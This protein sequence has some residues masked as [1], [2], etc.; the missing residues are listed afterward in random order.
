MRLGCRC[1]G[2]VQGDTIVS[3]AG[4][5]ST[6]GMPTTGPVNFDFDYNECLEY[7]YLSV[8]LKDRNGKEIQVSDIYPLWKDGMLD[9][10]F[11]FAVDTVNGKETIIELVE[12]YSAENVS[13]I[14]TD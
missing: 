3:T 6:D 5:Q 12:W 9:T 2:F 14:N 10:Y 7:D 8:S 4:A 1:A 11:E 13:E